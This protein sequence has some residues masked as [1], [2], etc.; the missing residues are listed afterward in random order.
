MLNFHPQSG[1]EQSGRRP[2]LIVS[3]QNFHR[4]TGMALVCP[5]T[6]RDNGFPLHLP[7]TDTDKIKGFVMCEHVKC[8]DIQSR[9]PDFSETV[10]AE[11]LNE[12]L[13]AIHSFID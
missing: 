10:G 8:L 3:N 4:F 2:A 5:I 6:S 11:L 13:S 7:L 9:N 1:R 12:V